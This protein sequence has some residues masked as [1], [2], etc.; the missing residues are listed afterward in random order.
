M[1]DHD[2]GALEIRS[3]HLVF[4]LERR[5]H[6]IDRWRLPLP[7][8]IPVAALGYAAGALVATAALTQFP[9]LG[10]ALAAVPA[11]LKY[12]I[13]PL[14]AGHLLARL[15]VD[16]RPAHRHLAALLRRR[17]V[18]CRPST[19]TGRAAGHGTR[20][21]TGDGLLVPG[22]ETLG[23]RP[24][25]VSGPAVLRITHAARVRATPRA[26]VELAPV[27]LRQPR[28]LTV[29]AGRRIRIRPHPGR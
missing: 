23:Q 8:G 29:P 12:V 13:A 20:V 1:R 9:L 18:P 11:P 17:A 16:G 2:H 26:S 22:P 19:L 25:R 7:H 10:A 5:I 21:I 24:A 27:R 14:A 4:A 28:R 15:R 3:F 6:R